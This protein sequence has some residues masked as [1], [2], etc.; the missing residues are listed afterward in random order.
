MDAFAMPPSRPGEEPADLNIQNTPTDSTERTSSDLSS[1]TYLK[2]LSSDID[3]V[4]TSPESVMGENE[5]NLSL[6]TSGPQRLSPSIESSENVSPSITKKSRRSQTKELD[7]KAVEDFSDPLHNYQKSLDESIF[8]SNELLTE[9][10]RKT[11]YKLKKALCDIVLSVSPEVK[12]SVPYLES[13]TGAQC[14]LRKHFQKLL[15]WSE[16]LTEDRHKPKKITD[17]S[18]HSGGTIDSSFVHFAPVHP[19]VSTAFTTSASDNNN[20]V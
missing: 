4:F 11:R 10:V 3:S 8:Q 18:R 17:S 2:D 14:R 20:Q 5:S 1:N 7:A 12:F 15:Y 19:F 16:H 6:S 13:E 9:E